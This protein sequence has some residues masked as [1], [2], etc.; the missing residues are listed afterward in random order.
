MK[1]EI[2]HRRKEL[3]LFVFL[4]AVH[5]MFLLRTEC[6]TDI[7]EPVGMKYTMRVKRMN[8]AINATWKEKSREN[9]TGIPAV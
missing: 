8:G 9:T 4:E 2:V 5:E 6:C 3:V 1:A 7:R